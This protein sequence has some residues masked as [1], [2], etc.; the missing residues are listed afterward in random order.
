MFVLCVYFFGLP[1]LGTY[2]NEILHL[3]SFLSFFINYVSK[4]LEFIRPF[5]F[6]ILLSF[7]HEQSTLYANIFQDHIVKTISF[8]FNQ[9]SSPTFILQEEYHTFLK[10][11]DIYSAFHILKCLKHLNSLMTSF[12]NFIRSIS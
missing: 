7:I 9:N 8:Y 6:L 4:Q 1:F 11:V 3:N 2:S 5:H 10:Y 12:I